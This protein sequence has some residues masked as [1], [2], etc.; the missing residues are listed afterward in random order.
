MKQIKTR[1]GKEL[2]L[3]EAKALA[4]RIKRDF[5]EAQ[6]DDHRS[7]CG[8]PREDSR[9]VRLSLVNIAESRSNHIFL[10]Y[11]AEYVTFEGFKAHT[12]SVVNLSKEQFEKKFPNYVV[13]G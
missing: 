6:I 3:D 2:S 1:T 9:G 12:I 13:M 10:F 4:K 11:G 8:Y 7:V 5:S